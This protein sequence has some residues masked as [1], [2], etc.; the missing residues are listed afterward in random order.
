MFQE[1]GGL[2]PGIINRRDL[3]PN[4]HRERFA[5]GGGGFNGVWRSSG[6]RHSC[7]GSTPFQGRQLFFPA[8]QA[9]TIC[10]EGEAMTNQE[11]RRQRTGEEGGAGPKSSGAETTAGKRPTYWG[12]GSS[13]P[14]RRGGRDAGAGGWV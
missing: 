5:S 1:N 7:D 14:R 4:H 9:E 10:E 13:N 3:R 6:R 12:G 11:P 8:L 2:N